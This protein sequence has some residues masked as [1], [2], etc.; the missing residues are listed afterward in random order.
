LLVRAALPAA[1]E[2][3]P[4]AAGVSIMRGLMKHLLTIEELSAAE[5]DEILALSRT[6]KT[7]RGK[8]FKNPP[9]EGQAVD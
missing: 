4:S 3:L 7:G 8:P 6:L 9:R 5:I 2:A 1:V